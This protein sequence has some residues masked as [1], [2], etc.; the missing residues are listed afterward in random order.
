MGEYQV[1]K[2]RPC[3]K[4]WKM[5]LLTRGELTAKKKG[6]LLCVFDSLITTQRA[7]SA[8]RLLVSIPQLIIVILP[9]F[10]QLLLDRIINSKQRKDFRKNLFKLLI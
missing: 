8:L 5:T 3:L 7:I 1:G 4:S 2:F 9:L 6:I 10:F